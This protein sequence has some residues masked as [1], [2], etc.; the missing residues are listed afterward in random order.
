MHKLLEIIE[1]AFATASNE[2]IV[3]ECFNL[4]LP[5]IKADEA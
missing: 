4:M 3:A 5:L 1:A 2:V